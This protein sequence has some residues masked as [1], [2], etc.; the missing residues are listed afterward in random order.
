MTPLSR[1]FVIL[2]SCL[3]VSACR[4]QGQSGNSGG[5]TPSPAPQNQS[6]KRLTATDSVVVGAHLTPEEIED[7]KISDAYQPLYHLSRQTDCA[8][9][10]SLC[11]SKI[12]PMAENSKFPETRSKFLFLANRDIAGCEMRA[13]KYEEAE[14]R[15]RKLFDYIPVWPGTSD[16]DYPINFRS[17][18]TAQLGRAVGRTQSPL[19]RNRS[20]YSISRSRKLYVPIHSPIENGKART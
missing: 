20:R 3:M 17:I 1:R 2:L 7:G 15:Y 13:G 14:A 12:I 5:N 10:T 8:Q 6:S 9:I 16:S 19:L 11:E 4:V 18:G